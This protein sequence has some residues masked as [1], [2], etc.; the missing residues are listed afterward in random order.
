MELKFEVIWAPTKEIPPFTAD[1]ISAVK[2]LRAVLDSAVGTMINHRTLMLS[3]AVAVQVC[4]L[5]LSGKDAKTQSMFA[6]HAG[7]PAVYVLLASLH[8]KKSVRAQQG[9]TQAF[10]KCLDKEGRAEGSCWEESC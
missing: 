5:L 6:P 3:E 8:L 7:M 2:F 9:R 1:N 10:I 4:Q